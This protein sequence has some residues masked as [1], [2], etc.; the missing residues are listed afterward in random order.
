ML[1][2]SLWLQNEPFM[3]EVSEPEGRSGCLE[4]EVAKW[5]NRVILTLRRWSETETAE[6][7]LTVRIAFGAGVC[8]FRV[9]GHSVEY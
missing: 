6:M 5:Q 2:Q 7:E 3:N 1:P 9:Y 8:L 4:G